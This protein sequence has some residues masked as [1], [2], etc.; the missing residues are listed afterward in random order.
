MLREIGAP[1][2][3]SGLRACAHA[4]Y[5]LTRQVK[6]QGMVLSG[7][8]IVA[9]LWPYL[10]RLKTKNCGWFGGSCG[11]NSVLECRPQVRAPGLSC[12][13]MV[14]IHLSSCEASNSYICEKQSCFRAIDNVWWHHYAS[15]FYICSSSSIWCRTFQPVDQVILH[16]AVDKDLRDEMSCIILNYCYV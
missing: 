14:A 8:S 5:P 16:S 2:S 4:S 6:P 1:Q 9:R 13:S 10:Q 3:T 12:F 11:W 7:R 15:G